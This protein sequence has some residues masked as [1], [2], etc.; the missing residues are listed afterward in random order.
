MKDS[1]MVLLLEIRYS[2]LWRRLMLTVARSRLMSFFV[3]GLLASA[4]S[5]AAEPSIT[6]F[7]GATFDGGKAL[8]ALLG[9]FS[10]DHHATHWVIA[11]EGAEAFL[12][13]FDGC[14]PG[15]AIETRPVT[16][17]PLGLASPARMLFVFATRPEGDE[18][19]GCAP[20]VGMSEWVQ[21]GE[22]WHLEAKTLFI[23]PVGAW[24]NAPE[25]Q[26]KLVG[27]GRF[28]AFFE[29]SFLAQGYANSVMTILG[30]HTDRFAEL[31]FIEGFGG[32][33]EGAVEQEADQYS[34]SSTIEVA[35]DQPASQGF[36]PLILRTTGTKA[37][38]TT[39][40]PVP[41][42]RMTRFLFTNG[43]YAPAP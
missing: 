43:T 12:E 17:Q 6:A 11:S 18:S 23:K 10:P 36:F 5:L 28:A 24:G 26:I 42:N 31:L 2:T 37:D 14:K 39:N 27:P 29:T 16:S 15:E 1:M 34:F 19:H 8:M 7:P 9:N 35:E 41:I 3:L 13:H 20:V 21:D 33:N 22:G 40:K 4:G 25:P 32:S 38:E 30:W